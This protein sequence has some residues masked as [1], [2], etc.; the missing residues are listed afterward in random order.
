MLI[1]N[2]S[3]GNHGKKLIDLVRSQF[4]NSLTQG[5]QDRPEK[6]E[7]LTEVRSSA[8]DY[9]WRPWRCLTAAASDAAGRRH[10][11]ATAL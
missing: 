2:H 10:M 8:P 1:L 5:A 7:F 11:S 4:V 9:Q 6:S 3:G